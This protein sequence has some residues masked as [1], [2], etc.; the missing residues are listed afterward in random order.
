LRNARRNIFCPGT[1]AFAP[2]HMNVVRVN[3]GGTG[4]ARPSPYNANPFDS[5]VVD[6]STGNVVV[7][8][9]T[10]ATGQFVQVAQDSN[11]SFTTY[12]ITVNPPASGHLDQPPPSNGTF[13][14]SFVFGPGTTWTAP[15]ALG[16]DL[17]WYNGG[18]AGGYLLS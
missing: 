16:M 18:S 5:V 13:V 6:T 2:Q 14:T 1:S 12:T 10:L 4:G 11:T 15:S 8:L 17:L 3:S 9:P 7:N